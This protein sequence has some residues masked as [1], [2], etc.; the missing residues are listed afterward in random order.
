M[1]NYNDSSDDEPSLEQLMKEL[2][3]EINQSKTQMSVLK[4]TTKT[5]KK[6]AYN[7][8]KP[9]KKKITTKDVV[10]PK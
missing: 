8:V 7:M 4:S 5:V 6:D 2:Q 1:K 10:M 9:K 3:S